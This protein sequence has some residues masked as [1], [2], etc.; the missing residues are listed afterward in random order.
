M[1]LDKETQEKIKELQICEQNYQ[2]LLIQK[3]AFQMELNDTENALSEVS[4]SKDDVF[5]IIGNIMIKTDKEKTE[6]ELERKKEILTLRL[7][8]IEKQETELSSQIEEIKK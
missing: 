4:K 3:Q 5:K 6:K 8:S 7:S 2:T 1:E